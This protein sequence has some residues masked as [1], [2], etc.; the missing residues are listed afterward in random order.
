MDT[1]GALSTHCAVTGHC[2]LHWHAPSHQTQLPQLLLLFCTSSPTLP[3]HSTQCC[4]ADSKGQQL[5]LSGG[6]QMDEDSL[7]AQTILLKLVLKASISVS[8]LLFQLAGRSSTAA[9][10]Q[11]AS[12]AE[13]RLT[14][15]TLRWERTKVTEGKELRWRK[16]KDHSF[17]AARSS[18]HSA[19]LHLVPCSTSRT[20]VCPAGS[21]P[22]KFWSGWDWWKLPR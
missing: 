9:G 8:T 16:E 22:S 10:S 11:R 18:L 1:F 14:A 5:A 3:P 6:A 13:F 17:P 4:P 15:N 20:D 2:T 12:P 7:N 21:F 19:G